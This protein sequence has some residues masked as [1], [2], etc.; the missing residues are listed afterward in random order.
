MDEFKALNPDMRAVALV[1][2]FL[3]NW[4]YMETKMRHAI[5]KALGLEGIQNLLVCQNMQLRNKVLML[6]A[7]VSLAFITKAERD[8]FDKVLREIADYSWAR[9]MCAHDFFGPDP[10]DPDKVGF[11]VYKASGKL[12]FPDADWSIDD[13]GKAFVKLKR[14]QDELEKMKEALSTGQLLRALVQKPSLVT[15]LASPTEEPNALAHLFGL[16][17]PPPG[18]QTSDESPAKPGTAGGTPPTPEAK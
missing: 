12:E 11:L 13:F 7:A 1:G 10:K 16:N 14:L 4:A 9:N 18:T 3:Q 2:S 17:R 5:G 8:H 15:D 6:R